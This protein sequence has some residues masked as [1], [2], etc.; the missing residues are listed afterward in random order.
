MRAGGIGIAHT[1][2]SNIDVLNNQI[3]IPV[4]KLR[5]LSLKTNDIVYFNG[6]QSV[7]VG[8]TPGSATSVKYIVGEVVQD[9]SIPTRTIHIPNHP[10]ETGQKVTLFKNNGANRFDVGR[11]P[12]VAEFKVPHVGQNSLDV[13]IINKGEDYVGIL[14]TKVGIGSTSE[15]LFF[16]SKGSTSGIASGLYYFSSNHE[17]VIG[18]I[19]KVT[20]TVL[21]NVS[22][23]NTTTHNL[24][25]G[26][27]IKMNVI[28]KLSVGIG[29]TT[30]ISVNYNSEY[31]K[32][33]I[34]PITFS[35]SDVETNRIDIKIMD[36]KLVIKYFIMEEPLD[37][38]LVIIMLTKSVTDIFNLQKQKMI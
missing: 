19:D 16:Y 18:D 1:L 6:A 26:D 29:T 12:N 4:K 10:F 35:A 33:L 3:N 17:Q 24:Q 22:A 27:V 21:T 34:N 7:G 25:E 31:E 32:L 37:Y 23:A 11:T 30:P 5:N 20:T 15:G 8:T 38:Q 13:Y 14:T 36:L 2:G 9:L 28:P